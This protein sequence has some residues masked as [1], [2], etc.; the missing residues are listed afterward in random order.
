MIYLLGGGAQYYPDWADAAK[1]QQD[2]WRALIFAAADTTRSDSRAAGLA[3]RVDRADVWM[4]ALCAVT[5]ASLEEVSQRDFDAREWAADLISQT[6]GLRGRSTPPILA[7]AGV[8]P[9]KE[10][11]NVIRL[12]NKSP[13]SLKTSKPD[14]QYRSKNP[15]ALAAW[16]ARV[17]ASK[18]AFISGT[19]FP[20]QT[21][22]VFP[23]PRAAEKRLKTFLY[24]YSLER[25]S[26]KLRRGNGDER[27][28]DD[29][30][31]EEEDDVD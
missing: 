31:D 26:L 29:E 11:K 3:H 12:F 20:C 24:Y 14:K 19:P 1:G 15:G 4:N 21:G 2:E 5:C 6:A 22:A 30:D 8:L 17:R 23:H 7:A 25:H 18:S 13:L 16:D 27:D 10:Y 9:Q 28:D